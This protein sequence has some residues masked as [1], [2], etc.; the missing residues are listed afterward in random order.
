MKNLLVLLFV[1]FTLLVN[2][3][4]NEKYLTIVKGTTKCKGQTVTWTISDYIVN[5]TDTTRL[6]FLPAHRYID[7]SAAYAAA[8]I[9]ENNEIRESGGIGENN[10]IMALCITSKDDLL[11]FAN[12]LIYFGK[13]RDKESERLVI[14]DKSNI[15]LSIISTAPYW[16]L[17]GDGLNFWIPKNS[18]VKLGKTILKNIIYFK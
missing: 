7:I 17:I 14:N 3:Q 15:E 8:R 13:K 10:S 2:G 18:A 1:F 4:Q 9:T 16:V 6:F 5:N 11:K 12:A